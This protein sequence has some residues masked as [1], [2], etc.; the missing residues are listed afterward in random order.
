[1]APTDW[2]IDLSLKLMLMLLSSQDASLV[3]GGKTMINDGGQ[4]CSYYHNCIIAT[5]H[6]VTACSNF[7]MSS[8]SDY[9]KIGI[10]SHER[11]PRRQ[12]AR[13]QDREIFTSDW[14]PRTYC[15]CQLC[16]YEP[17]STLHHERLNMK[18]TFQSS[19]EQRNVSMVTTT[20]SNPQH[21]F[22]DCVQVQDLNY[23]L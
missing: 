23:I 6:T 15:A 2:I 19:S 20:L 10:Q 17:G 7:H 18:S 3:L 13:C 1:M 14:S 11:H 21:F 5:P 22:I 4:L 12:Q 8:D 9:N 16:R